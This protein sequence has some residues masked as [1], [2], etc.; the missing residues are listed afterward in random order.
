ME[1]IVRKY[2]AY[3]FVCVCVDLC[4]CVGGREVDQNNDEYYIC[5]LS[6]LFGY[7]I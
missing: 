2:T 3:L 6:R 7:L 4:V 1:F 5:I